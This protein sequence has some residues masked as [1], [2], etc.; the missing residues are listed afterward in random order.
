METIFLGF[1]GAMFIASIIFLTRR[2]KSKRLNAPLLF[3]V[4]VLLII[5]SFAVSRT[6]ARSAYLCGHN[7]SFKHVIV[8]LCMVV[9]AFISSRES[10]LAYWI[11]LSNPKETMGSA[12]VAAEL[13]VS[14][15]FLVGCL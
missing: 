2:A 3:G 8:R 7:S 6:T 9:E 15:L 4:T 5:I 12:L 11:D 14:Q 1:H 13:L 10:P